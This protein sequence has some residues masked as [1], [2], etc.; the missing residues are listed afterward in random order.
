MS[1]RVIIIP[2]VL[3]IIMTTPARLHNVHILR[4]FMRTAV[5]LFGPQCYQ[6]IESR[7]RNSPIRSISRETLSNRGEMT[8]QCMYA[9]EAG[10]RTDSGS[11]RLDNK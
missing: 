8:Q 2:D 1:M 5:R 10:V 11:I 7:A 6:E 9:I 3:R 4:F